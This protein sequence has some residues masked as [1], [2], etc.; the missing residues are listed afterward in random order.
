MYLNNPYGVLVILLIASCGEFS[1]YKVTD[2]I[3]FDVSIENKYVG[4]IILGLFGEV[5]PVT[6]ENFKQIAIKGIEGKRYDGTK[7]HT[8]IERIMIQ[9]GDIVNND[10]SGSISIYGEYF[11]DENFDI[12]PES[13]GLLMM[14]NNGP[15]TNGCQFLITTMPVPWLYGKNVV[16]GKVLKGADVVHKIEHLKTDVEDHILKS[17]NII[18]SGLIETKPFYETTKNYELTLWA[19][20]KAGWFPLG[21]SFAVLGI[22]QYI[23]MQLNKFD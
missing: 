17:V 19:W 5:A 14:A 16:F 9:G 13:S 23:L 12:E 22:F 2:Q 7:F 18:E 1:E 3:Y 6:C 10:G 8:A 20:I 21:F 11:D 4:T 15:N